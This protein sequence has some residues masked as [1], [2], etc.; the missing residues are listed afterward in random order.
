M[1]SYMMYVYFCVVYNENIWYFGV[2]NE[3]IILENQK[4]ILNNVI[5]CCM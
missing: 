5:D 1:S 3:N 2:L 4:Y